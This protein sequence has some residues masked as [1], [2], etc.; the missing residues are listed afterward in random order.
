[1]DIFRW[2]IRVLGVHSQYVLSATFLKQHRANALV[3]DKLYFYMECLNMILVKATMYSLLYVFSPFLPGM[4]FIET[5]CS[6]GYGRR[7]RKL[8][9][10]SYRRKRNGYWIER[11]NARA[12]P[13]SLLL[14]NCTVSRTF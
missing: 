1:M 2:K 13:S 5:L 6:L 14:N 3:I 11:Q 7:N 12:K 8:R 9:G 4:M 10:L